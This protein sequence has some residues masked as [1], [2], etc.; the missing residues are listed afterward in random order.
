M[1][2]IT[3]APSAELVTLDESGPGAEALRVLAAQIIAHHIDRGHRGLAICGPSVGVGTTFVAVNLAVAVANAGFPTMLLDANLRDPGI[4]RMI[5]PS[6][7]VVG[8][9]Q[10]L[11][12]TVT[13][14]DG[15]L[16]AN[17][18]PNLSIIY[19]G[20]PT[21]QAAELVGSAAFKQLVETCL[22]D[23]A[24][25]VIDTPAANRYSDVL[26]ISRAVG[27]SLIV[28]RRN[29]SYVEDAEVLSGELRDDGVNVI[30]ALLNG[31]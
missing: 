11:E 19:S 12:G 27:H 15:A 5:A 3:Y 24:F 23:Y 13:E 21:E 6:G 31:A 20:G 18:L 10:I 7:T 9:R 4:Q 28:T 30:G 1:S 29:L 22:R 8:L 17:P 16:R 2:E 25:T 14:H 26:R